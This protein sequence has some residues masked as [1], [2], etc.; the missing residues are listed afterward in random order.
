ANDAGLTF[1]P[2]L[3]WVKSGTTTQQAVWS[4]T[5]NYG[6]RSYASTDS[7]AGSNRIQELRTAGGFQ[8]GTD[9]TVN[10]LGNSYYYAAFN[11]AVA[12]NPAN[13]TYLMKLGSYTGT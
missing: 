5:E 10:A 3:V 12:K 1:Q 11:G 6:D 9:A 13:E 4:Q 7:A 8:V 2:D